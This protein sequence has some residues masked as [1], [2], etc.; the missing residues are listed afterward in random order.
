MAIPYEPTAVLSVNVKDFKKAVEWYTTKLG[1]SVNF[2]MEEM[3]WADI[4]TSV[5]GLSIGISQDPGFVANGGAALTFS[6]TD[7][8]AAR[9]EMESAGVEFD[10]DN[11]VI[12]GAVILASFHDLDGNPM[13]LAQSLMPG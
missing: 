10:G 1:F 3:P 6:V 4:A 9:A 2:I 11:D 12:P 7:I 5:P 13:M 8:A